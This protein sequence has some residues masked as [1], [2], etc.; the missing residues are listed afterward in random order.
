[1][2]EG[3]VRDRILRRG[4]TWEANQCMVD[5]VR[6]L[7]YAMNEPPSSDWSD[8]GLVS[9]ATLRA[10]ESWKCDA[11]ITD[12]LVYVRNMLG[13]YLPS[14]CLRRSHGQD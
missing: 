4:C 9:L 8:P 5:K 3:A 2:V 10:L 14:W 7:A 1:M 12:R 13:L 11:N 6:T